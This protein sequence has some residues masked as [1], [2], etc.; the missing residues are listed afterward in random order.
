LR[1]SGCWVIGE[2][3]ANPRV[4][5]ASLKQR[6]HLRRFPKHALVSADRA[7]RIGLFVVSEKAGGEEGEKGQREKENACHGS[8][9]EHL[10]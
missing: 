4:V 9:G 5:I 3:I 8:A 7:F 6:H 1:V 2:V 10:C